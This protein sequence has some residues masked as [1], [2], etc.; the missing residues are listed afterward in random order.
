M[1]EYAG[2]VLMLVESSFPADTRVRN[3]AFT[4]SENGYKVSVIALRRPG[5][6]AHEILNGVSVYRIPRLT[7]FKKLASARQTPFLRILRKAQALVGYVSEYCYFTSACFLV[8]L[9]VAAREGFDVL[10]AHNPPD[11]L[12]LVGALHKI[13]GKQFVFDHHD[14]CPELYLSRYKTNN[15][16]VS[17]ALLL[18]ERLSLKLSDVTIVTNESYRA[19]DLGRGSLDPDDVFVVRNGPD[20]ERVKPIA[21]DRALTSMGRT[22]LGYIGS[23]NP[24]DGIDY[25]LR[26]LGHLVH[27]LGRTD[28]Y[29]VLVGNGD[30]LEQL[31][32]QAVSLGIGDYVL[33]TGFVSDEEAMRYLSTADICLDPD[34]SSPLNDVS[35]WIKVMEYMAMGK[36]IVTFDLKETRNSAG[37]AAVYVKPNDEFEFAKAIVRLMDEPARRRKMGEY[38]RIRVEKELSWNITS[39][40]LL[41][42]YERLFPKPANCRAGQATF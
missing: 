32:S 22:I 37:E 21:P 4:L 3:E 25:L 39:Q 6:K 28:F 29:C 38:G 40:N 14:L 33:F 26:A 11:T 16:I 23:M 10:H 41:R 12:F 34:P 15:N 1:K 2:K 36:P 27:K 13:F 24:Q 31:K 17:R 30:S 20:L 8:S 9:Y 7:L 42:A 19:I 35:T 5:E 18:L